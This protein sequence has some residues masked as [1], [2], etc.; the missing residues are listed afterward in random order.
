[1]VVNTTPIFRFVSASRPY[2][3][4]VAN[5]GC[6]PY[7]QSPGLGH[8]KP[9]PQEVPAFSAFLSI[10][11]YGREDLR[12]FKHFSVVATQYD[13]SADRF[14][15]SIQSRPEA[16][17]IFLRGCCEQPKEAAPHRLF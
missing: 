6:R 17:A 7:R 1:M 5:L 13:K 9:V 10:S 11:Q 2:S 8:I 14:L 12:R 16:S 15:I 3:S 4:A